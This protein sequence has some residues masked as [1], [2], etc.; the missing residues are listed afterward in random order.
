M[1]GEDNNASQNFMPHEDKESTLK[2]QEIEEDYRDLIDKSLDIG[3]YARNGLSKHIPQA[4]LLASE[5]SLS[6]RKIRFSKQEFSAS[7]PILDIKYYHLGSQNNNLFYPFN[8]QLNYALVNYFAKFE[9]IKSNVI[10]FLSN[11]LIAPFTE[12]LFYQ[13]SDK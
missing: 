7:K 8:D 11:L 9:I 12:K 4:G 10:R 5:L 13:N 2:E 3:S 1:P 6:L